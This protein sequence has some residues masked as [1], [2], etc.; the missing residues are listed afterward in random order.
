MPL[1]K[2]RLH[3]CA[4]RLHIGAAFLKHTSYAIYVA[5]TGVS[6]RAA[7]RTRLLSPAMELLDWEIGIDSRLLE[8]WRTGANNSASSKTIRKD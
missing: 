7:L 2:V 1:M 6:A 5:L 8:R 4:R 3:V